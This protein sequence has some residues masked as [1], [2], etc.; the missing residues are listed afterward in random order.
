M[1]HPT[2][3]IIAAMQTV[4]TEDKE[5]IRRAYDFAERAHGEEKRKSGEPYIVHPHAIATYLATI[6]MDRDTIVAGILHDT[7]EDTHVSLDEIEKEFGVTIR[8]LVDS[9]TKLSRLRYAGLER[10]VESLRHLLVATASDIRVIIIK[11]ADRLH[12]MR[13]IEFV[14]PLEKRERIARDT[15]EVY[16]PI[17]ERLGMGNIKAEL[18]DLAFSVL[19][20][21]RYEDLTITIKETTE[22][23]NDKLEEDIRDLKRLLAENGIRTFRTEFRVKGVHS[24]AQKTAK[25]DG[26]I[27]Q[28]YDLFAL[29]VVVKNTEECYRVL[30]IVHGLWRPIPGKVKDYLAFPKPNGYRSLHTTVITHR[31]VTVELQIRTEEMHQDAQFG[32]ASH[33]G[34]K[35]RGFIKS[36]ETASWIYS[37]IPS[38]KKYLPGNSTQSPRWLQE[39]SAAE[40]EHPDYE[41]FEDIL[42]KDFF[43]ER[44]FAFTPKGDV[45]DLP[46]DATPI[47][48]AYNIHSDVGDTMNGA[49]VNGKLVSLDTTLRNGDVVEITMSK[50]S[51]PNKKWLDIAKTVS[52]KA[53]IRAALRRSGTF[54]SN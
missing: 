17:A 41:N 34:Y 2:D 22:E 52:A 54:E 24:F 46:R 37:L 32:V 51:H 19:E 39:L 3:S 47:D 20:P 26:D 44:I 12:N 9:L 10:H 6:G 15:M 31:G 21:A 33:F 36:N 53:Q 23:F 27:S 5:V 35:N 11:M 38:L 29:R 16:V 40:R 43:A 1:A 30:G 8:F 49:K 25:Y 7:T 42:K 48:F 50:N 13:T 18:E 14:E 4:T 45:I 28:V